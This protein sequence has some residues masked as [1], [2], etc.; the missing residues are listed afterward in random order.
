MPRIKSRSAERRAHIRYDIGFGAE[1]HTGRGVIDAGTRDVS[2]GGCLLTSGTPL[3]EA[4]IVRIELCLTIDGIQEPDFPRLSVVGRVQWT[5]DGEDDDG[6]VQLAG[7]RFEGMTAAQGDWLE[8]ILVRHGAPLDRRAIPTDD[9]EI[10]VDLE[11]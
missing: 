2:R 4:A 8:Q 7:V 1:V 10:D 11:M 5:A 3:D 6:P 9:V